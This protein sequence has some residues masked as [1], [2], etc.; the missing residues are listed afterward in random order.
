M[1]RLT[2]RLLA[3]PSATKR[4]IVTTKLRFIE[5]CCDFPYYHEDTQYLPRINQEFLQSTETKKGFQMLHSDLKN[6]LR[7]Q[8]E[9]SLIRKKKIVKL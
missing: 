6:V 2:R 7:V 5:N 4:I 3:P 8:V 1:P 9:E